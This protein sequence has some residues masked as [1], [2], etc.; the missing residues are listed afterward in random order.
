V[1]PQF[2]TAWTD[3]AGDLAS[4]VDPSREALEAWWRALAKPASPHPE[5]LSAAG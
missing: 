2:S 3:Y 1:A 4:Y 5:A